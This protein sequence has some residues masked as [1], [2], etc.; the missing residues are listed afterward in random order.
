MDLQ[1]K[2]KAKQVEMQELANR[3][4]ML[5]QQ[6]EALVNRIVQL[7]GAVQALQELI[8]TE[9]GKKSKKKASNVAL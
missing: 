6:R 9:N 1:E 7:Q 2:L 3:L 5:N 8:A 4:N